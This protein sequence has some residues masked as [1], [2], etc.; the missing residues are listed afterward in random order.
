MAVSL[1]ERQPSPSLFSPKPPFRTGAH[2]NFYRPPTT[3]VLRSS[4]HRPLTPSGASS[5]KRVRRGSTTTTPLHF[6]PLSTSP[7]TTATSSTTAWSFT[8][9][10][11]ADDPILRSAAASPPPFVNTYYNLA[12]GLDTPT[13]LRA[14]ATDE[15]RNEFRRDAG[16]RSS[17]D[18][19]AGS[20]DTS[21]MRPS[22]PP[23]RHSSVALGPTTPPRERHSRRRSC[24]PSGPRSPGGWTALMAAIAGRMWEFCKTS[25]FRGFYAGGGRGYALKPGA[26]DSA[27]SW[28]DLAD[29]STSLLPLVP[30]EV[31]VEINS[32]STP[33][34]GHYPSSS[35]TAPS[36]DSR[37]APKRIHTDSSQGW[38]VV[39]HEG[40]DD[41]RSRESTPRL[42]SRR[43]PGFQAVNAAAAIPRP[44]SRGGSRRSLVP[45]SRRG[46][47]AATGG[48]RPGSRAGLV[49]KGS[50]G[51]SRPSS[52]QSSVPRGEPASPAK[53]EAQKWQARLRREERAQDAS[54]RRL[55]EQLKAMIKEGK[56]ALG[57]KIEVEAW[58]EGDGAMDVD[59]GVGRGGELEDEGFGEGSWTEGAERRDRW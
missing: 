17:W 33:I 32:R 26:N 43:T 48:S 11:P 35:P 59:E 23:P 29:S 47:A 2:A 8:T 27:V 9:D 15:D 36:P 6:T 30:R 56:E 3:P 34:P 39:S 52:R 57:T 41:R 42:A 58:C 38:V 50:P 44:V 13:A 5:R 25:A 7:P 53:A 14:K 10:T 1:H 49:K 55:N 46:A 28:Q 21:A 20:L 54:I 31:P 45:V 18:L 12:G 37:P 19:N 16:F 40:K 4:K 22:T 51:L 24:T